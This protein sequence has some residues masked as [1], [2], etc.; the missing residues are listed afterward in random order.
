MNTDFGL[1]FFCELFKWVLQIGIFIIINLILKP[2]MHR[3]TRR[4][5]NITIVPSSKGPDDSAILSHSDG[6]RAATGHLPDPTDVLNQSGHVTTVTVT[7]TYKIGRQSKNKTET[8]RTDSVWG[9]RHLVDCLTNFSLDKKKK[10][11]N[12]V[13]CILCTAVIQTVKTT[14]QKSIVTCISLTT[15]HLRTCTQVSGVCVCVFGD[16]EGL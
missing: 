16:V 11:K 14:S 13:Q 4:I 10:K 5:W 1:N 12:S 8:D 3:K 2:F 7:M 6:V 15:L 9:I